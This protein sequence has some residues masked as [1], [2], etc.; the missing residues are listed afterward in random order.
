M[1]PQTLD[2][3]Y[4]SIRARAGEFDVD[5]EYD[6]PELFVGAAIT[7]AVSHYPHRLGYNY[8]EI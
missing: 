2:S 6:S 7:I 5:K 1:C 8:M 4:D 3:V